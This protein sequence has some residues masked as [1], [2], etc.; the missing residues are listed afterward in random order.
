MRTIV[1]H[2]NAP[3]AALTINSTR[4]SSKMETGVVLLHYTETSNVSSSTDS[5]QLK[6]HSLSL[7]L[8]L[9]VRLKQVLFL[10]Y[11]ENSIM[12]DHRLNLIN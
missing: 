7:Q 8:E 9:Q 2:E 3:V 1:K 12:R 5:M 6:H 11:V 4:D 10:H